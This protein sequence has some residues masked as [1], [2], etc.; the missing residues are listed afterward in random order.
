MG[1]ITENLPGVAVYLDDILVS[2]KNAKDYFH[3]LKKLLQ[4]LSKNVYVV[5]KRKVSLPNPVWNTW[6]TFFPNT[7]FLKAPR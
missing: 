3:N 4:R 2:G 6:V 7:E 1:D 5:E